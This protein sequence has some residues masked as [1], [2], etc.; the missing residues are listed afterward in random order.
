V[1]A[2]VHPRL[3]EGALERKDRAMDDL[4][5]GKVPLRTGLLVF[6][7]AILNALGRAKRVLVRS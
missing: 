5:H 4:Y 1:Q 2:V 6:A 3:F 7:R